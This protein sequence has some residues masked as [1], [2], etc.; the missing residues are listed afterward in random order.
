MEKNPRAGVAANNLAWLYAE[1]GRLDEAVRLAGVAG[2]VLRDRPEPQDTL[3]WA[4]YRKGLP[5]LALTAFEQALELAPDNP[6]Y[7]YHLGL[8]HMRVG[9]EERGRASLRRALALKS[10]FAY[11]AEARSAL[12]AADSAR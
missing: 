4:Y 8:A 12:A 6:V 1:D 2:E 7:H 10:D 9:D 11:A 5:V 3:G